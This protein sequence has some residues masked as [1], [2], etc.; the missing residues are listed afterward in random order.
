MIHSTRFT[1]FPDAEVQDF[2][3]LIEDL[4]LPDLDDRHVLAVAIHCNADAIITFNQKDFPSKYV[5][6]FN[7]DIYTPDK[8]LNLLYKLSP[9]LVNKAF[10]NQLSSLK[11][12]PKTKD[13]LIET[14]VNCNLKSVKKLIK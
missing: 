8:F 11:N 10:Y 3:E 1:A 5:K 13:E 2:E 4:K 14:L 12:P 9:E 6:E 7:I